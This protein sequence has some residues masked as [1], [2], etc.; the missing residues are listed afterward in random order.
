MKSKI[1]SLGITIMSIFLMAS[2][3]KDNNNPVNLTPGAPPTIPATPIKTINFGAAGGFV[4]LS[5]TG[6]TSAYKSTITGD[7]GTS[8]ISGAAMVLSCTEV[9]GNVFSVDAAGPSCKTTDA[10][11][12]TSSVSDM[13]TA[14]TDA[15][16][17]IN[18]NSID[19]GAGTI[20]G[21]TITPGL[22]KWT[23]SVNIPTDITLSG[24]ANDVWIFQI[25]GNLKMSSAIKI[26]LS[27]GALAK[28]IYWQ[29]AGDATLG[30]TSHFEGTIL[31]KT[32]INLQTGASIN[33]KLLSQT[34]VTLQSSTVTQP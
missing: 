10:T 4:I 9:T 13:Q 2:C 22:H 7:I 32:G 5:K 11:K 28:N 18:P 34:A 12:L 3:H 6:I 24:G 29:V 23:T 25:A 31:G 16:G 21:L 15:E 19:L 26:I 20:G 17:R 33:G 1:L 14:Y 30:T 8:P 27:G